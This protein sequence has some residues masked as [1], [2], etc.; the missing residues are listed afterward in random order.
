MNSLLTKY[1]FIWCLQL[2]REVKALAKLT[3]TNIVG[4][5]G[6]WMEYDVPDLPGIVVCGQSVIF[7]GDGA[8]CLQ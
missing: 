4:Y 7:M 3:H 8:F 2:L 6:A 5:N 1:A